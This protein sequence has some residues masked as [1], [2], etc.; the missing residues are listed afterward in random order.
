MKSASYGLR[1]IATG[2]NPDG[3]IYSPPQPKQ[4]TELERLTWLLNHGDCDEAYNE[5]LR[6]RIEK[7]S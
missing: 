3:T 4:Q 2:K 1:Q 7:L 6:E 5:R